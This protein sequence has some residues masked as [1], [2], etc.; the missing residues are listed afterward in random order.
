MG[1]NLNNKNNSEEID[2]LQLFGFFENKLKSFFRLIFNG[3]KSV[4]DVLFLFF[5]CYS[6]ISLKLL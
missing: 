5:K 2:L 3:G 1:D 6:K 4:F